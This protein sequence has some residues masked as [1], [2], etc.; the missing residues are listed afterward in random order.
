MSSTYNQ[1]EQFV[2]WP[3]MRRNIQEVIAS[4][5]ICSTHDARMPKRPYGIK[6]QPRLRGEIICAEFLHITPDCKG[7]FSNIL[8]TSDKIS[9]YSMFY[10]CESESSGSTA[11]AIMQWI[12]LFGPMDVFVS[13]KGSAW[14]AQVISDTF[15]SIGLKLTLLQLRHIGQMARRNELTA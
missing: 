10:P 14:T 4:C 11:H 15:S 3:G 6:L 2:H 9:K 5:L 12:A 7:D 13:D 1:L 8:I